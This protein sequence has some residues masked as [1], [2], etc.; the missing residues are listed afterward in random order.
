MG[1]RGSKGVKEGGAGYKKESTKIR[2]ED[3]FALRF[4]MPRADSYVQNERTGKKYYTNSAT[5]DRFMRRWGGHPKNK[6]YGFKGEIGN[7]NSSID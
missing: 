2:N 1:G 7:A 5:Y 3:V 6:G 4:D